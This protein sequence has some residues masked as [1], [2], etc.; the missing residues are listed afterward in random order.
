MSKT[1]LESLNGAA[2]CIRALQNAS[3]IERMG[4]DNPETNDY[5]VARYFRDRDEIKAELL[6]SFGRVSSFQSGFIAALAEY[7]HLVMSTGEPDL[8]S[9]KPEAF[10]TESE[11]KENREE[12]IR[13]ELEDEACEK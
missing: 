1:T 5:S 4:F 8:F 2:A 3:K 13:F 11:V 7:V 9:W 10:M 6:K 12:A